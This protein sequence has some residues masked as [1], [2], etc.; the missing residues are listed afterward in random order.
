MTNRLPSL[1]LLSFG[2]AAALLAAAPHAHAHGFA[3]DHL[4]VSTLLIDDANVADEASLPTFSLLPQPTDSGP[5]P[6]AYSLGFEFDK[7]I[8][9]NFGFALNYGYSWLTQPGNKTANGW[10]NLV[11]TLKDKVYVNDKHE[12]MMSVGVQR[13]FARTGANGSNGAVLDNDDS[14]STIPTF[15]FAKGFGDLPVPAAATAGLDRGA[16]LPD[17]RQEAEGRSARPVI[18]STTVSPTAGRAACRCST[19]CAICPRR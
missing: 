17:R 4:F 6:L 19:A 7:R 5:A 8:T 13:V 1:G 10:D 9:E 3:G 11:V 12:F 16:W 2:I 18:R 14:S 15:Y